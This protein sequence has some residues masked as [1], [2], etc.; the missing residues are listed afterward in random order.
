MVSRS[1]FVLLSFSFGYCEYAHN[2]WTLVQLN[3]ILNKL[4]A[5]KEI[6]R[7]FEPLPE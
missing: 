6:N 1:L 5:S 4:L 2:Q 3:E 7:Q